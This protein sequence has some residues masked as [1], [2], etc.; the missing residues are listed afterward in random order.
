MRNKALIPLMLVLMAILITVNVLQYRENNTLKRNLG[1]IYSSS[2]G[3]LSLNIDFMSNF[4]T[5][6]KE[7]TKEQF[8]FYT[9]KLNELQAINLPSH[10]TIPGCISVLFSRFNSMSQRFTEGKLQTKETEDIKNESLRILSFL[11]KALNEMKQE[12]ND[13]AIKYFRYS[14]PKDEFTKRIN[15]EVANELMSVLKGISTEINSMPDEVT[16]ATPVS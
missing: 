7:L 5:N 15:T 9:V 8:E 11:K 6:D 1:S 10:S 3:N 12:Y 13:D 14:D 16:S 2:I 4:L